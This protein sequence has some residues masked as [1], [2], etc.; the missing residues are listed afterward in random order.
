VKGLYDHYIMKAYNGL[1][2]DQNTLTPDEVALLKKASAIYAAKGFEYFNIMDA[3]SAYKKFPDLD[4]L[5]ALAR[6]IT[7]YDG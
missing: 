4:K 3:V 7:K 2:A 6:K 1:K 5:A